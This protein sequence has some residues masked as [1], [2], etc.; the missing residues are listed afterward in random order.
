MNWFRNFMAGRYGGDHLCIALLVL[1]V[2]LSL[3]G[4]WTN[5]I[6]LSFL[7]AVPLFL[8]IYRMMSK[9]IGARRAENEKFLKIIRPMTNYMRKKKAHTAD[10]AH[11]YFSCPSCRQELRVP[12]GK[13]KISVTCPKCHTKFAKKT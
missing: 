8:S 6:W 13:G 4:Q 7:S 3:I 12:R 10:A 5:Q 2:L 11:L 1:S 9:K